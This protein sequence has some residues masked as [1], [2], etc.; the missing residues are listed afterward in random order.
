[1]CE[2]NWGCLFYDVLK[3]GSNFRCSNSSG[4]LE[5]E[6]LSKRHMTTVNDVN[7]SFKIENETP[8][9][10][11][12]FSSTQQELENEFKKK[13]DEIIQLKR[14]KHQ[15][16]M[17]KFKLENDLKSKITSLENALKAKITSVE[18]AKTA[19]EMENAQLK[20]QVHEM[21]EYIRS[22]NR[23]LE[24]ETKLVNIH[25]TYVV[26]NTGTLENQH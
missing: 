6:P 22:G 20:N 2:C 24:E 3:F 13:E 12:V 26:P 7:C 11:M 15:C 4:N 18:L 1:M 23:F 25:E 17:D 9:E 5:D 14:E 8:N 16:L 10:S 19:L 21:K